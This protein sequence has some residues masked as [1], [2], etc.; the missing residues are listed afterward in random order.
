MKK[1]VVLAL[2]M[3]GTCALWAQEY[4]N[5]VFEGG[6][7]RGIAYAGSLRELENRQQLKNIERVAGTSAGAIAALLVSLNYSADEIKPIIF[8]TPFKEFNDGQY[9]FVGGISRTNNRYGWYQGKE[10]VKW[11][12]GLIEAKTGNKDITFRELREQGFR[13]L[14]VTGTSLN[15]QQLVVFS[16]VSYPDMKIK[17][18]IRISIS[19]PL[20]FEAVVIDKKGKVL[21]I[22]TATGDY[23]IMVDGGFTANFPIFIFDTYH[24]QNGSLLRTANM[25]TLGLRIDTEEQIA[26]DNEQ[27]GLAPIAIDSFK[28]YLSAFYNYILENLNRPLLTADDW[29]RTVSISSGG[30]GPKV[31]ELSTDQKEEL[32]AN[33][34]KAVQVFFGK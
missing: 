19:I 18:A 25:K 20:Y 34:M 2:L 17:D 26:Y 9:F 21:D 33:G 4:T 7:M 10:F 30:I 8:D 23:D 28:D 13:D 32:Y 24:K 29:K 6:G 3:Q 15:N 14:Y 11:I 12:E 1:L 22:E 27:K 16:A 31:R 5:L